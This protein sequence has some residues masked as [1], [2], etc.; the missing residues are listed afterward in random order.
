MI[1]ISNEAGA[2][3]IYHEYGDKLNI[4]EL[5]LEAMFDFIYKSFK[6]DYL[7]CVAD[8][9]DDLEEYDFENFNSSSLLMSEAMYC[10]NIGLEYVDCGLDTM[11]KFDP[12]NSPRSNQMIRAFAYIRH[13]MHCVGSNTPDYKAGIVI[14]KNYSKLDNSLNTFMSIICNGEKMRDPQD[15]KLFTFVFM[16]R[17][18]D[19]ML[20]K[21]FGFSYSKEGLITIKDTIDAPYFVYLYLRTY[22]MMYIH[23]FGHK[24]EDINTCAELL[25]YTGYATLF[26]H[27][28]YGVFS[29]EID[30]F[31]DYLYSRLS[32]TSKKDASDINISGIDFKENYPYRNHKLGSILTTLTPE[33]VIAMTYKDLVLIAKNYILDSEYMETTREIFEISDLLYDLNTMVLLHDKKER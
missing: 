22:A 27:E 26:L 21:K 15:Q 18:I 3:D 23:V 4:K 19:F 7:N 16:Q 11:I 14:S 1:K 32:F 12:K 8:Y 33:E 30:S 17:Y 25:H 9:L 31:M 20:I 24:D 28:S 2:N 13:K 5:S 6:K 10:H 29:Y